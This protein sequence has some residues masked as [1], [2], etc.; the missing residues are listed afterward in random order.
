MGVNQ[1]AA[2]T[3]EEFKQFYRG[4]SQ[5]VSAP[6]APDGLGNHVSVDGLPAAVGWR[7]K[8]PS[9]VTVAKD[10]GGCGSCS[11]QALGERYRYR[12]RDKDRVR[13]RCAELC[14]TARCRA[15]RCTC[16]VQQCE[17]QCVIYTDVLDKE[18]VYTARR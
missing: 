12:H 15:S 4:H 8:T 14:C 7:I 13:C 18:N 6:A 3:T 11:V 2:H 10:Q 1:F 17:G 5:S 16:S 9:V